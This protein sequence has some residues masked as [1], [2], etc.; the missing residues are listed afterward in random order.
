MQSAVFSILSLSSAELF[1]EHCGEFRA[2]F[3]AAGY[4]HLSDGKLSCFEQLRGAG[5]S[6][7]N[8]I[9]VHGFSRD[10]HE[11]IAQIIGMVSEFRR[12][13]RIADGRVEI[14]VKI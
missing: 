11:Q 8:K 3:K 2:V 10:L 12:D 1:F 7:R 14:G 4:R 9:L 13:L 6:E 5:Y